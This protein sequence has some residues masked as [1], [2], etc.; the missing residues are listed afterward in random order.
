MGKIIAFRRRRAQAARALRAPR[1]G[2]GQIVMFPGVRYEYLEA[3]RPAGRAG[4]LRKGEGALS[5]ARHDG[6]AR[7]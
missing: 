7:P 3:P 1:G 6:K 5:R 2:S 4:G